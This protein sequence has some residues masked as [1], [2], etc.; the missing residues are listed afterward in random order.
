MA[1]LTEREQKIV[2]IDFTVHSKA[3]MFASLPSEIKEQMLMAI[4]KLKGIPYDQRE[5]LDLGQAM[6]D[7]QQAIMDSCT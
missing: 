7:E 5:M 1:E 4:M 2:L 3:G 6:L